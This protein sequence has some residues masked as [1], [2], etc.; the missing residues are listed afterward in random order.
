MG[1]G[2]LCSA[3]NR[4]LAAAARHGSLIEVRLTSPFEFSLRLAFTLLCG[5]LI[6]VERQWRQRTAGLRT[7][8]LVSLGS[9]LFVMLATL[10]PGDSSPTRITGQILTGGRLKVEG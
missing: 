8:T 4:G 2:C 1:L 3:K 5:A 6:G 9:A 10:V 7:Y